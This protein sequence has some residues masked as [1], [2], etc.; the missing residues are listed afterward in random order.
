MRAAA[1]SVMTTAQKSRARAA[2]TPAELIASSIP[3]AL[4]PDRRRDFRVSRDE[5]KI[6]CRRGRN[7]QAVTAFRN[8]VESLGDVDD[9][10]RQF[11]FVILSAGKRG[12][13]PFFERQHQGHTTPVTGFAEFS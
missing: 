5:R 4:N 2:G 6:K 12:T 8:C 7:D 1:A 9:F 10:S 11:R 3:K 13:C